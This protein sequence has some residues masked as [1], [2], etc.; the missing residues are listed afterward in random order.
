MPVAN[1]IIIQFG[2]TFNF[3]VNLWSQLIEPTG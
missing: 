2:P 3:E 1:T